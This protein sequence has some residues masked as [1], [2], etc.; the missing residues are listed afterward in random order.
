MVYTDYIPCRGS[1]EPDEDWAV[2]ANLTIFFD[3][4]K[5]NNVIWFLFAISGKLR[6][7]EIADFLGQIANVPQHVGRIPLAD[8]MYMWSLFKFQ[9]FTHWQ[10]AIIVVQLQNSA[11][12]KPNTYYFILFQLK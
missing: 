8:G 12:S 11:I 3:F 9:V 5:K 7:G 1:D 4:F 10:G 2:P 6:T